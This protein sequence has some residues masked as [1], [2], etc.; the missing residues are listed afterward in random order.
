MSSS[1]KRKAT[2]A[3]DL[4]ATDEDAWLMHRELSQQLIQVVR[5]KMMNTWQ[6]K[7]TLPHLQNGPLA[8]MMPARDMS[9]SEQ[10]LGW[11]D[12]CIESIYLPQTIDRLRD[13]KHGHKSLTDVNFASLYSKSAQMQQCKEDLLQMA[14]LTPGEFWPVTPRGA[15]R[16]MAAAEYLEDAISND[17]FGCMY[18]AFRGDAREAWKIQGPVGLSGGRDPLRERQWF[19]GTGFAI[20]SP[21]SRRGSPPATSRTR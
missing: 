13:I 5:A 9:Y 19:F 16:S 18:G 2:A 21:R 6:E 11:F 12:M 8:S 4:V 7:G 1:R 14:K 3:V 15:Y 17:D 10:R 20:A